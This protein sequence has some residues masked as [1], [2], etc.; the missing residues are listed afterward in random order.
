M[1]PKQ[2]KRQYPLSPCRVKFKAAC[3]LPN[4]WRPT[5]LSQMRGEP[6]WRRRKPAKP[7][8][9]MGAAKESTYLLSEGGVGLLRSQR[10][11]RGRSGGG[12]HGHSLPTV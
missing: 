6:V 8:T 11:L 3:H 9:S 12:E 10:F 4:I 5:W 1:T 7:S 2:P